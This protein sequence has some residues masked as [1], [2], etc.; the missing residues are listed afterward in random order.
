MPFD[1]HPEAGRDGDFPSVP[2]I[3]LDTLWIQVS[4]TVCNLSCTHCF[5]SCSPGNHSHDLMTPAQVLPYLEEAE[6]LGVRDYYFT[7]GEPFVNPAMEAILAEALRRGPCT[8]LTNGLLINDRRAQVLKTLSDAS[9]YS[10][11]IRISLDGFDAAANDPIRGAGTFDRIL[12]GARRLAAAGLDPVL[13]VTEAWEEAATEAGRA[14][15]LG[16]MRDLGLPRPRLKVMPL[17]RLGAEIRRSR[18]YGEEE[19]LR[20]WDLGPADFRALQC[21]SSRMV[22]SKGVYVCPILIE[23]GDARLG[24]TLEESLR[25]YP[26]AHRACHTCHAMGLSCRT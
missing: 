1:A 23:S 17:L 25:P 4:G 18:P 7:G 21:S 5:I 19:S 16:L 20:G 24:S 6:A 11:D 22:T 15:L 9:P 14:R 10:L 12:E 3:A 8:V 2:M 13:T 26:L